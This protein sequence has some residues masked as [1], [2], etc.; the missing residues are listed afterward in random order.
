MLILSVK[1]NVH[2][3]ILS[4]DAPP[5]IS[6]WIVYFSCYHEL[7]GKWSAIKKYAEFYAE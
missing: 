5:Y 2:A 7:S 1:L 4:D 3:T 6:G